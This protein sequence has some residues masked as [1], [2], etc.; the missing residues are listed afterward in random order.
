MLY[1]VIT[2]EQKFAFF[3]PTFKIFDNSNV[4][5]GEITGDWKAWRNNFV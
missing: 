5:V 1:E 2:V 3:K 4:L